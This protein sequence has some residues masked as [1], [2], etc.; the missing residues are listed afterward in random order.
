MQIKITYFYS[1]K[2]KI[3]LHINW[4]FPIFVVGKNK[5]KKNTLVFESVFH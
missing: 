3:N 4:I 1:K 2:L 5:F